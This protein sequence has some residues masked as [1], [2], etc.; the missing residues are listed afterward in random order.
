MWPPVSSII[1]A[2]GALS[3][4]D[5]TWI[6]V[7]LARG[8]VLEEGVSPWLIPLGELHRNGRRQYRVFR[9]GREDYSAAWHAVPEWM[10]GYR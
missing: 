8:V 6:I 10:G 7:H 9:S 3:V 4:P 2:D 1:A 5:G